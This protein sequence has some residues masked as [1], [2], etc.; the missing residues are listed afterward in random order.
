MTQNGNN[1]FS[2]NSP[3]NCWKSLFTYFDLGDLLAT[4][5][6]LLFS[7]S[8]SCDV[9][10]VILEQE[11]KTMPLVVHKIFLPFHQVIMAADQLT[12]SNLWQTKT[13]SD[14]YWISGPPQTPWGHS[15]LS[16]E[17]K[18]GVRGLLRQPSR[19]SS[20]FGSVH[21]PAEPPGIGFSFRGGIRLSLGIKMGNGSPFVLIVNPHGEIGYSSVNTRVKKFLLVFIIY[22]IETS[23]LCR[24]STH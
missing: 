21:T 10:V 13:S 9:V 23:S 18:L 24:S 2:R 19:N 5:A 3:I 6:P 22:A 15:S 4:L 8:F 16:W 7:G 20:H 1:D 14:L 11:N 12:E 17:W